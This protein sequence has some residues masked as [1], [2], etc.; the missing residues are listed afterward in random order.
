[1]EYKI[2]SDIGNIRKLNEDFCG[3]DIILINDEQ[4]GIFV[5]ADGM[6]GHKKGEIASKLAV[7]NLLYF[8][9]KNL[10]KSDFLDEFKINSILKEAY[11]YANAI[12]YRTSIH[13][14]ECNGMGTTLT[15]AIIYKDNLFIANVGDSRCYLFRNENLKKI[16]NDNS[17][18]QE[19]IEK[20]VITEKESLN[21]PQRNV[22]TRAV[23]TDE[24]IKIDFYRE[25]IA[26]NDRILLTTD[27]L[28]NEVSVDLIKE[29]LHKNIDLDL[30]CSE[31]VSSANK[32][33]GRDNISVICISI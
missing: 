2:L 20:G 12:V 22:I 5:I 17:L 8:L 29:I 30:C 24:Y 33:G 27:G 28:T 11:N 16:T 6:G 18:I 15:S 19:L 21:H 32:N 1:M 9:K 10:A 23:G 13:E 7:E 31:L 4:I 14:E 25:N 26:K 3:G